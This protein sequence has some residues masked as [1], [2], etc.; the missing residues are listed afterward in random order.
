MYACMPGAVSAGPA[1]SRT[2]ISDNCDS[3]DLSVCRLNARQGLAE[4][5]LR[6]RLGLNP[7][8]VKC[9]NPGFVDRLTQPYVD[10][11]H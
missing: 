10:L 3:V 4:L 11:L 7:E 9:H 8:V 6:W 5:D 1:K 2:I